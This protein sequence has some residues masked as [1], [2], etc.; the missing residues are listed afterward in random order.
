MPSPDQDRAVSV[1]REPKDVDRSSP[2]PGVTSVTSDLGSMGAGEQS[3]SM[4]QMLRRGLAPGVGTSGS[5]GGDGGS[6]VQMLVQMEGEEGGTP[7]PKTALQE[8][9]EAISGNNATGIVN[10]WEKLSQ[11]AKTT[12]G[13][14][15]PKSKQIVSILAGDNAE[16]ASIAAFNLGGKDVTRYMD[17]TDA[18]W[19]DAMAEET[20]ERFSRSSAQDTL[21]RNHLAKFSGLLATQTAQDVFNSLRHAT[22]L[23]ACIDVPAFLAAADKKAAMWTANSEANAAAAVAIW[24]ARDAGLPAKL[25]A[26]TAGTANVVALIKTVDVNKA[27]AVA[28]AAVRSAGGTVAKL[29]EMTAVAWDADFAGRV[30]ALANAAEQN[31]LVQNHIARFL[32]LQPAEAHV[33]FAK[34]YA[35]KNDFLARYK[36]TPDFQ[37]WVK[38]TVALDLA[39]ELGDNAGMNTAWTKLSVDDLRVVFKS[40]EKVRAALAGVEAIQGDAKAE[41][42]GHWLASSFGTFPSDYFTILTTVWSGPYEL[43]ALE[44]FTTV[45]QE[46]AMVRGYL[47]RFPQ[48]V[49]SKGVD[50]ALPL[51]YADADR[52]VSA[53]AGVPAF[54]QWVDDNDQA[55]ELP[56]APNTGWRSKVLKG[57]KGIGMQAKL[58]KFIR[59]RAAE[60]EWR[61]AVVVNSGLYPWVL[62]SLGAPVG[63]DADA[64]LIKTLYAD[65]T[66]VKTTE[67]FATYRSL[68]T[69]TL[70]QSGTIHLTPWQIVPSGGGT[71]EFQT[72]M[73][74]VTPD[75]AALN[76][77]L[78]QFGLLPRAQVNLAARVVM[79]AQRAQRAVT[80]RGANVGDFFKDLAGNWVATAEPIWT[81]LDTSYYYPDGTFL[82]WTGAAT[83]GAG[84]MAPVTN[85]MGHAG[86][87]GS[88]S[89]YTF[90]QN[91]C[92]H[93]IGHAVGCK[94]LTGTGVPDDVIKA[95]AD[96]VDSDAATFA[97]QYGLTSGLKGATYS[98]QKDALSPA[99]NVTGNEIADFLQKYLFGE[100]TSGCSYVTK[101][102]VDGAQALTLIQTSPSTSAIAATPY[103]STVI[104]ALQPKDKNSWY[105]LPTPPTA[106][107]GKVTLYSTRVGNKWMKFKENYWTNRVSDYSVSSYREMFA[108]LYTA[109]YSSQ[110]FTGMAEATTLFNALDVADSADFA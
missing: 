67:R 79:A 37:N 110:K 52:F 22:F 83:A 13:T 18:A 89:A 46:D 36:D 32:C 68:Y 95:G 88:G 93:E 61:E 31:E 15:V 35:G 50:V 72:Q 60:A 41:E 104:P 80:R 59:K 47:D 105:V 16:N 53:Y 71:D 98:M 19:S 97:E 75:D 25:L 58:V 11:E 76:G 84:A 51:L 29:M 33:A 44:R 91:H 43:K 100:A 14:N 92:V 78:I 55:P 81:T 26:N 24:D 86:T 21:V 69:A 6:P 38:A 106:V 96:W 30:L 9:D 27:W 40:T 23:Q 77:M 12:L 7:P 4:V 109:H 87:D 74:A 10:A 2:S 8:L 101:I 54:Q 20:L 94:T 108:E 66:G 57:M 107:G 48:V 85:R 5:S 62:Q 39:I 99:V 102:G 56:K 63:S 90:F 73:K 45:E 34:L 3:R 70:F 65:G 64:D 42:W 28:E 82:L 17:L 1:D 103:V 49:A